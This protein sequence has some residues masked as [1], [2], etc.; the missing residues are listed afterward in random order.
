[1]LI[2]IK[3][4][5]A[6]AYAMA[7]KKEPREYLRG[8][9]LETNG[10]AARMVATDGHR[11]H[12][13][14]F[15]VAQD[16]EI[17]APGRY[18]LPAKLVDQLCKGRKFAAYAVDLSVSPDRRVTVKFPDDT[19][20]TEKLVTGEYVDYTRVIPDTVSG[21]YAA[22]NPKYVID[23]LSGVR[24][25]LRTK[26]DQV[27]PAMNGS[28]PAVLACGEFRAVIMPMRATISDAPMKSWRTKLA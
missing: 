17:V 24:D 12:A 4:I 10:K 7:G 26:T 1:M 21:E 8:V 13:V 27:F 2:N 22:L 23:A 28:G 5:K 16:G 11:M 15:A 25:Y 20:M 6:V 18:I 14:Q 19:C 9:L 3:D